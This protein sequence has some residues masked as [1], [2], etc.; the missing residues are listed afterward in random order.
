MIEIPELRASYFFRWC[1]FLDAE[2]SHN[3][4]FVSGEAREPGG[5][6][7]EVQEGVSGRGRA[8]LELAVRDL[9]EDLLARLL[10]S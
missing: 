9:Q 7:K 4:C 10:V 8:A 3:E 2:W 1:Q 5:A 6:E